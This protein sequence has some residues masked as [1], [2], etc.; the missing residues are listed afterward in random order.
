LS[1]AEIKKTD[2]TIAFR[3]GSGFPPP[4]DHRHDARSFDRR[5]TILTYFGC[6]DKML[7]IIKLLASTNIIFGVGAAHRFGQNRERHYEG[8]FFD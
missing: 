7:A 6:S 3:K 4:I 2:L 5:F 8:K 1:A